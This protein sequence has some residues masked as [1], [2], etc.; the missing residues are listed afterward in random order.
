MQMYWHLISNQLIIIMKIFTKHKILP[1][2]KSSKHV[3]TH[4][5]L[6]TYPVYIMMDDR[7]LYT[8]VHRTLWPV[9]QC[10]MTDDCT[11]EYTIPCGQSVNM[12]WPM[13]VH[14][15]TLYP[16]A[17]NERWPMTV[18]RSTLYLVASQS[19]RDDCTQEYTI[20]CGQ[21]VN[22]GWLVPVHRNGSTGQSVSE[23]WPVHVRRNGSTGQSVSEGWPVPVHRNGSTGQSV[24]EGWPVHVRRNGSTGQSVRDDRYM[25][26]GMEALMT[27]NWPPPPAEVGP[28]Q[29]RAECGEGAA[30]PHHC[31]EH[32]Q[33]PNAKP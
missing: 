9:S 7:W 33:V 10:G 13:T 32:H 5:W 30:H 16:V 15:S 28:G 31:R 26:T 1:D 6:Y 20:P 29:G 19:M 8:G 14:M 12:G 27:R 11:Q 25:Y 24:R 2:R 3:H 18:C 22:E 21:S 4:S 23:G 17:V